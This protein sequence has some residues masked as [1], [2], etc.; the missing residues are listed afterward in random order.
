M[1]F[2]HGQIVIRQRGIIFKL[3]EWRFGLGVRGKFFTVNMVKHG[4]VATQ[5]CECCIPGS[6]RG[7]AEWSSEHSDLLELPVAGVLELDDL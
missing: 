6:V 3:K 4:N 7:Q 5:H 1:V 2:L